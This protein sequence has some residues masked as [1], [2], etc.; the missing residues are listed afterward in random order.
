MGYIRKLQSVDASHE[1]QR[2][3]TR[4]SRSGFGSQVQETKSPAQEIESFVVSKC[5]F[6]DIKV[7]PVRSIMALTDGLSYL[8]SVLFAAVLLLLL[9]SAHGG[10]HQMDEDNS[11]ICGDRGV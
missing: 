4:S 9:S 5:P 8:R 6:V 1:R 11:Q 7:F 2:R 3:L 10:K